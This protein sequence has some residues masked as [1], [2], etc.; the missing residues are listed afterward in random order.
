MERFET[1]RAFDQRFE[2]SLMW[3]AWVVASLVYL[4][5]LLQRLFS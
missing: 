3:R 5:V 4:L 1:D 2:A